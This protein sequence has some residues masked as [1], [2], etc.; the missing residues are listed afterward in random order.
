MKCEKDSAINHK[1]LL[2]DIKLAT[3]SIRHNNLFWV[4]RGDVVKRLLPVHMDSSID[5]HFWRVIIVATKE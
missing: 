1:I 5:S 2:R 3:L 4:E